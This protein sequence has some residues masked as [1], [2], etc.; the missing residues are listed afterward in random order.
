MKLVTG[1][2]QQVEARST[3]G[4]VEKRTGASAELQNLH[5]RPDHDAGR[6]VQLEHLAVRQS[7]QI[8]RRPGDRCLAHRLSEGRRDTEFGRDLGRD[9]A[10]EVDLVLPIDRREQLRGIA[11]RFRAPQQEIAG[12]VERVVEDVKNAL[13]RR[14][15]Q[16]DQ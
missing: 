4:R 9:V 13:L 5:V 6:S 10:L 11:N 15:L 7:L 16:I 1:D 8:L 3:G 12:R 2:L 14:R